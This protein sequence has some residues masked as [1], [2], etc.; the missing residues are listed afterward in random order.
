MQKI[1]SYLYSNRIEL[2]ADLAGFSVE[3]TNVYQ[4]HIKIYNGIDNLLEFDIK[5]ADQKR[6]DL[7]S[8]S[9]L[10]MNVMDAQGNALANSPYTITPTSAK[11]IATVVIPQDDLAELDQQF[12]RYSVSCVKDG[13][14]TLL[15]ADSRFGAVGTLELVGSAMPTFRDVRTFNSFTA[16]IDL[17]GVPTWHSSAIPVTYYEAEKTTTTDITLTMSNLVGS[18]WVEGTKNSTIN[19]EAFKN[20][21]YLWSASYTPAA[22]GDGIVTVPTIN[23]GEYKYLRVSFSTPTINGVGSSFVVTHDNGTYNVTIRSG[24]T[25][26]AVGSQMKVLGSLLGGVDGINDLIISVTAV[27]AASSTAVSSYAVS[28]INA[29]TWTGTSANGT[30][31]NIVTGTNITGTIDKV[32][33]D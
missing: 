16:E 22:P 27:D 2:L 7:T 23:I 1:S 19:V 13:F 20:A 14:D 32:E 30:G 6:I 15:Y 3:F 12:L 29:I 9:N 33:V 4:R 25:G 21:T 5:N 26:Y 8:V 31:T 18:V 24:G 17:H 11:G 10:E 28:S